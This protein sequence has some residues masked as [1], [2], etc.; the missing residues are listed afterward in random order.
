MSD[1]KK[2][3]SKKSPILKKD[4]DTPKAEV[5]K[6]DVKKFIPPKKEEPKQDLEP[7]VSFSRWF[8]SKRYKPHW[9]AGMQAY[10][11]T[12]RRRTMSA[13]DRLFKNY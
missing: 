8:R 13:W 10:T 12:T 3:E 9:A 2:G 1:S 6:K 5:V 4:Y 7:L 11:D